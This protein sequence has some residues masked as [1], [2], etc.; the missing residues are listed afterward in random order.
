M[1]TDQ[2]TMSLSI[3]HCMSLPTNKMIL[4]DAGEE[5]KKKNQRYTLKLRQ[6]REGREKTK[7]KLI[8]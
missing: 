6:W 3:N 2:G 1:I 5:K 7:E 8:I 4:H